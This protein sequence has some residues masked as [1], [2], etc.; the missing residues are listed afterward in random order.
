MLSIGPSIQ[1]YKNRMTKIEN[2]AKEATETIQAIGEAGCTLE[3]IAGNELAKKPSI[4]VDG[5]KAGTLS[6]G[7]LII[8]V[9]GVGSHTITMDGESIDTQEIEVVFAEKLES[10]EIN[11]QA[12]QATRAG[13]QDKDG[14]NRREDMD[15][16]KGTVI[17]QSLAGSPGSR[18]RV[19]HRSCEG[20]PREERT[21]T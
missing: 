9:L 6:K 12:K 5:E 11:V 1:V 20:E 10:K 16:W 4:L 18:E 19:S 15:R 7:S 13:C 17:H 8:T 14:T 2:V 21:N 3:I